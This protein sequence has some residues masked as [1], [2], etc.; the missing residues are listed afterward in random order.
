MTLKQNLLGEDLREIVP[1]K[2]LTA[3]KFVL[4][5]GWDSK[6]GSWDVMGLW[7]ATKVLELMTWFTDGTS[8]VG[9]AVFWCGLHER[10]KKFRDLIRS[11]EK[12]WGA[13]GA[14]WFDDMNQLEGPR[15]LYFENVHL[16]IV[17]IVLPSSNFQIPSHSY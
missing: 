17:D 4:E 8:S 16:L 14:Q 11:I 1:T 6:K 13:I 12:Q 7:G 2:D 9:G 15:G 10:F 3:M 5:E